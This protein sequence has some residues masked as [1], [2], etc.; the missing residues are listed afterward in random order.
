MP[1]NAVEMSNE[2]KKSLLF[3]EELFYQKARD[4]VSMSAK[5][6]IDK[7]KIKTPDTVEFEFVIWYSGIDDDKILKM[8]DRWKMEKALNDL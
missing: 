5:E 4:R 1:D 7:Y 2:P 8:Y 3:D 6:Y